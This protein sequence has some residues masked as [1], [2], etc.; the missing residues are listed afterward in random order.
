VEEGQIE[1]IRVY[2]HKSED[3]V[4][5]RLGK[6][7]PYP[8]DGVPVRLVFEKVPLSKVLLSVKK[9][10]GTPAANCRYVVVNG[11][12]GIE[13]SGRCENS[14]GL[15][16]LRTDRSEIVVLIATETRPD[17]YETFALAPGEVRELVVRPDEPVRVEGTLVDAAGR[18]IGGARVSFT[19]ASFGREIAEACDSGQAVT[20]PDGTFAVEGILPGP[21]PIS[22]RLEGEMR[23]VSLGEHDVPPGGVTDL[24]LTWRNADQRDS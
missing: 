3:S 12:G 11:D 4:T 24:R 15:L 1:S 22:V 13:Y 7:I 2:G 6:V 23:P 17:I 10:D 20:A 9:R 5:Y 8:G 16:D 19:P 18:A 14:R 21:H